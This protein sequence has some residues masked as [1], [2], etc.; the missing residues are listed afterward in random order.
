[1]K[2]RIDPY[3]LGLWLADRYWWGSSVG[4]SNTDERLILRFTRWLLQYYP[5]E[6]VKLKVYVACSDDLYKHCSTDLVGHQLL[7]LIP[8]E[9]I[10]FYCNKKLLGVHYIVYVNSRSLKRLINNVARDLLNYITDNALSYLAGRTDGD[11]S[12]DFN[13]I[14]LRIAYSN[15]NEAL[16]DARLIRNIIGTDPKIKYYKK[17]R[18][19]ISEICCTRYINFISNLACK[20]IR[21]SD[22]FGREALA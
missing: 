14:R 9:N 20:T 13:K 5:P 10:K 15:I 18:E 6:R 7:K 17:A 8:P 1:M 12:I 3:L 19:Y 21:F 2:E 22:L 4:L 16:I 11:G